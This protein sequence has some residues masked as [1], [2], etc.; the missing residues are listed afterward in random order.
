MNLFH[1]K[2]RARA[3]SALLGAGLILSACGS[4][5]GPQGWAPPVSTEDL[6]LVNVGDGDLLALDPA[7]LDLRWEF[8]RTTNE[9]INDN[10]N[11]EGIYGRPVAADEFVFVGAYSGEL[12]KI[13]A[14]TGLTAFEPVNLGDPVI[15][16]LVQDNG[17]LYAATGGGRVY[18]FNTDDLSL[19]WGGFFEAE[20]RIWATPLLADGVLYVASMDHQ[21][22]ALDAATGE[23]IWDQ[24]FRATGALAMDPIIVDGKLIAGSFDRRLYVIDPGTGI[25]ERS[26][27]LDDWLWARPVLSDNQ[28]S[29]IYVADLSGRVWAVDTATGQFVWD[30]PYEAGDNI[31]GAGLLAGATL[32]F[33]DT[34]GVVHFI[35]AS[36]GR[37]AS[38]PVS[39][40]QE[41]DEDFFADLVEI[42][43]TIY[44]Q[45]ESGNLYEIDPSAFEVNLVPLPESED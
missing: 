12:F 22:Y 24:P 23:Q 44:A 26:I 39:A 13:H 17:V 35:N 1:V 11:P 8:P 37:A 30:S 29:V 14:D 25:S 27:E 4:V 32:V 2:H 38:A 40:N 41:G 6:F 45:G 43:G 5:G 33:A 28:D 34:G 19:S 3:L 15:A 21:L 31:R 7:S 42:D 9:Q 20:D 18:A 16:D 36:D 10:T